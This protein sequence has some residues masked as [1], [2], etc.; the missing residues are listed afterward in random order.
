MSIRAHD[1]PVSPWW[2]KSS[3]EITLCSCSLIQ[4]R[5][6]SLHFFTTWHTYSM[7]AYKC[8]C[9]SAVPFCMCYWY[10]SVDQ[11]W[12]MAIDYTDIKCYIFHAP[13]SCTA[14]VSRGCSTALRSA[15]RRWTS[16]PAPW[17]TLHSP[18]SSPVQAWILQA[19][20][21]GPV[22]HNPVAESHCLVASVLRELCY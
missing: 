20:S 1:L 2:C 4:D 12:N 21:R 7:N 5:L 18:A 6:I 15:V 11:L 13:C 8:V 22:C 19:S 10:L 17:S 16:V 3:D 14:C 9:V